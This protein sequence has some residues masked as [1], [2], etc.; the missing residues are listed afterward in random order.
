MATQMLKVGEVADMIGW[1]K[2]TVYRHV[3]DR[4]FPAP[5]RIGPNSVRWRRDDIERWLEERPTT[6][7]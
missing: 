1:S 6:Q 3:K 5:L 4:S 2:V 7:E